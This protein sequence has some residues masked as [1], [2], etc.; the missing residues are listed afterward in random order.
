[1]LWDASV[2]LRGILQKNIDEASKKNNFQKKVYQK[3]FIF[4]GDRSFSRA[5]KC[6]IFPRIRV[7]F[8]GK[9][10]EIDFLHFQLPLIFYWKLP[11]FLGKCALFC[12]WKWPISSKNK[13]FSI[14]F[15]LKVILFWR[16]ID[17]FCRIPRNVTEASHNIKIR[18]FLDFFP[19]S[20]LQ[21]SES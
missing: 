1:M 11:G 14:N 3:I 21:Y 9:S 5:K 16:L 17:I 2:T 13:Y 20:L 4:R 8:N 15:F 18:H 6:N 19:E 12:S 10:M 7:I